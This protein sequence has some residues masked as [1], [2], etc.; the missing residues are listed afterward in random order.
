ME[1]NAKVKNGAAFLA[2]RTGC[3]VVPVGISG[4]FKLFSK[5][6]INYGAPIDMSKYKVKGKEKEY[7]E[8]ATQEIMDNIV[9]LTN[10][11]K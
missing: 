5:V 2:I 4:S 3:P 1:K 10:I 7:Q 9:M 6:Y 11:K 8:Q